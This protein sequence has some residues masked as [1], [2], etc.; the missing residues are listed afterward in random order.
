MIYQVKTISGGGPWGKGISGFLDF[1]DLSRKPW[2][3]SFPVE[4]KL[5]TAFFLKK[6]GGNNEY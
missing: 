4:E 6:R 1:L 3:V 2:K 5:S